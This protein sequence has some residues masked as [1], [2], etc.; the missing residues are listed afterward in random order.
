MTPEQRIAA[1][2]RR[3]ADFD[4]LDAANGE[5]F[6]IP[7]DVCLAN[8]EAALFAGLK[9]GDLDCVADALVMLRQR[10]DHRKVVWGGR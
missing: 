9:S 1:A 8:V 6:P 7:L 4:R 3:I 10:N 2:K 5:E